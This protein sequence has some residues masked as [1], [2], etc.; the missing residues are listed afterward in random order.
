MFFYDLNN[1]ERLW[2]HL[3]GFA[4]NV[5]GKKI[6]IMRDYF[7]R[8]ELF[9]FFATDMDY[10]KHTTTE[11][12]NFLEVLIG[13]FSQKFKSI[14][15]SGSSHGAYIAVNYLR[16]KNKGNVENL[17][18]F[19]PSFETLSLIIKEIGREKI[20]NWLEGKESLRI[21]EEGRE[22]EI[23]KEFARDIIEN[24]YEIIENDKVKFRNPGV[25]IFIVH[26]KND[27]IVP[28]E[29][30]K[31]FVS[32]VKVERFIEVDDDHQLSNT[33]S[34]IFPKIVKELIQP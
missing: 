14:T 17:V 3:H 28:V 15:L 9:S 21:I 22:I 16:F 31:L 32:Q 4:T 24:G 2:L 5:L 18:L 11:A 8:T 30:T 26:G 25:R 7:K 23:I 1:K 33:F 27:E 10:E 13:G 12:L 29:R 20:K 34:E 6:E 19:A